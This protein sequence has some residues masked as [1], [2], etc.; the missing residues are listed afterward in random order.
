M[1][2]FEIQSWDLIT[3][4]TARAVSPPHDPVHAGT[5]LRH[6]VHDGRPTGERWLLWGYGWYGSLIN[7]LRCYDGMYL[8]RLGGGWLHDK[9]DLVLI[10]Y[11][12]I[13]YIL[14]TL[15]NSK[16]NLL[17]DR[18]NP[19]LIYYSPILSIRISNKLESRIGNSD[20]ISGKW[21]KKIGGKTHMGCVP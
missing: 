9:S 13:I 4:S 12:H 6:P 14:G 17:H 20:A 8:Y 2:V 1:G 21:N 7:G 16:P 19:I 18:S 5:G 3:G 11:N 10:C 15:T